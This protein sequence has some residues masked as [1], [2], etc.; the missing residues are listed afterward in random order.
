MVSVIVPVYN[1]EKYLTECMES[2][3]NQSYSDI[4][5]IAINDGSTDASA[6]ILE[7]YAHADSRVRVITQP[8]RGVSAGRNTGIA[9]A[10]GEYIC[11]VDADDVLYTDA[12]CALMESARVSNAQIAYSYMT[13][14]P[15]L[16]GKPVGKK[17]SFTLGG[18]K[19]AAELLYQTGL[20]TVTPCGQ[21][22][23]AKLFR[24][25]DLFYEDHR[26]EDLELIPRIYAR[27]NTV[28]VVTRYFYHYRQHEDSFIHRF[29]PARF[30]SLYATES[31]RRHL[32]PVSEELRRATDDRYLSAAFNVFLLTA[33]RPAYRDIA[34]RAWQ[35][36]RR[37]RTASLCNP[38]VRLKNKAGILLSYL[39]RRI[40]S[41]FAPAPNS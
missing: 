21:I 7:H 33:R 10:R 9:A 11:F 40:L 6:D 30:D 1:A 20:L 39:G 4:E 12:I 26:Y 17:H 41:A 25:P 34:D 5:V 14:N 8:N 23:D 27:V 16:L 37:F 22:F 32:G 29:S 38:H 19:A 13:D 24:A 18:E 31:L 35:I 2:I 15:D 36:I 28:A 3:L